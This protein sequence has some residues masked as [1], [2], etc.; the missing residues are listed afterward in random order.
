MSVPQFM[1]LLF[2]CAIGLAAFPLCPTPGQAGVLT[3]AWLAL[4][5]LPAG[6]LGG[7]E[8]GIAAWLIPV[9]WFLALAAAALGGAG[10]GLQQSFD[11]LYGGLALSGL[12]GVGL[13]LGVR[14]KE[15]A[16]GVGAAMLLLILA[17]G[18]APSLGGLA[19]NSP[20][21]PAVTAQLLDIS[22][23]SLVLENAGF[24]W[25]RHP[26]IYTPAGADAID[27]TLRLPFQAP[28]SALWVFA[29]GC[30]LSWACLRTGIQSKDHVKKRA[31]NPSSPSSRESNP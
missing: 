27:P 15:N 29:V 2:L 24:D 31:S 22:P 25:M 28:A 4:W 17:L 3:F 10:G 8:A 13:S 20:W 1:R 23:V 30:A 21:S 11:W 18:A 26:A 12:F 14:T 16:L 7:A 19:G 6:V 5:A 9:G